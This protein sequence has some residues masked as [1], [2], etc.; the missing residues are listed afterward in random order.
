M[1]IHFQI[2]MY[3]LTP[4]YVLVNIQDTRF[5]KKK[6]ISNTVMCITY[7]DAIN[8]FRSYFHLFRVEELPL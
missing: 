2:M 5:M 6:S 1:D 8:S 7:E 4:L 3:S